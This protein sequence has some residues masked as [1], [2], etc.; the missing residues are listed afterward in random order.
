[1]GRPRRLIFLLRAQ[2]VKLEGFAYPSEDWRWRFLDPRRAS[3][4]VYYTDGNGNDYP[5]GRKR[6]FRYENQ[7]SEEHGGWHLD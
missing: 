4:L 6:K 7:Q 3:K 2:E 5:I 1:M